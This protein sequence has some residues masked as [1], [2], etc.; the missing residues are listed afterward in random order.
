VGMNAFYQRI[1]ARAIF[2]ILS[3]DIAEMR[4]TDS[5]IYRASR[6]AAAS[7]DE[8]DFLRVAARNLEPDDYQP[9]LDRMKAH[10]E[11]VVYLVREWKELRDDVEHWRAQAEAAAELKAAEKALSDFESGRGRIVKT[12]ESFVV[13]EAYKV[14]KSGR[15]AL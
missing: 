14:A 9:L 2:T 4:G 6:T 10:A 3:N 8:N 7:G 1:T 11:N 15:L 13:Q 12:M 5:A